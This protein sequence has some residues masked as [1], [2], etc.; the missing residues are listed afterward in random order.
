MAPRLLSVQKRSAEA[1]RRESHVSARL[2]SQLTPE[3]YQISIAS[4]KIWPL[5]L[6]LPVWLA[7]WTVGGVL[8]VR[9]LLGPHSGPPALYVVLWLVLWAVAELGVAYAWLWNAFGKEL[10]T[11]RHSDLVMKRDILGL[12]RSRAF[13]VSEISHLRTSGPFGS[14]LLGWAGILNY[15]SL[16]GGMIAFE[17]GERPTDLGYTLM[18]MKLSK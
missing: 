8:T 16:T 7:F 15:W 4:K 2:T 13:S 10:V 11:V 6:F 1:I 3:G 17:S 18:R 9:S 12:G 14:F 5:L